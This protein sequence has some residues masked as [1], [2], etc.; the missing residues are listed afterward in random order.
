MPD[1]FGGFNLNTAGFNRTI[2]TQIEAE[3]IKTLSAGL[4][5]TP[6]GSIVKA[7]L[8][9][10]NDGNVRF[11]LFSDVE[12]DL[13]EL[14]ETTPPGPT[15]MA[16]DD[17]EFAAK[18]LGNYVPVTWLAERQGRNPVSVAQAKVVRMAAEAYDTVAR[19]AYAALTPF[20]GITGTLVSADLVTLAVELRSRDVMPLS[21]GYYRLVAH[22]NAYKD[23]MLEL[24][25]GSG[26][27]A[28]AAFGTVADLQGGVI[29]RYLGFE[30]VATTRGIAGTSGD[31][32]K[33]AAIGAESLAMSEVAGNFGVIVKRSGTED[34]IDQVPM[35]IGWRAY[36]GAEVVDISNRSDGAGNLDTSVERA[37]VFEVDPS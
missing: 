28:A 31:K 35:T 14:S 18:L 6:A 5:F 20:G 21:N 36:V 32:Q 8:A 27:G 37:I 1:T 30:F 25:G 2:Q 33:V 17:Q 26:A 29:G 4:A 7:T 15:F 9:P 24:A 23:L 16:G 11:T 3:V 10:G 12:P 34:P 19:N 22:P 13:T